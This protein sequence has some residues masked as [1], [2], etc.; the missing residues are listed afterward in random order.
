VTILNYKKGGGCS[1]LW[2]RQIWVIFEGMNALGNVKEMGISTSRHANVGI[3]VHK[4]SL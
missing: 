1:E 3:A 4:L 2:I